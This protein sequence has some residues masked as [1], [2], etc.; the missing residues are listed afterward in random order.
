MQNEEWELSWG[1]SRP[2]HSFYL[3]VRRPGRPVRRPDKLIIEASSLEDVQ[4]LGRAPVQDRANLFVFPQDLKNCIH[5][6]I[7][8]FIADA[9]ALIDCGPGQ[10]VDDLLEGG[11]GEDGPFGGAEGE[12]RPSGRHEG[13]TETSKGVYQPGAIGSAEPVVQPGGVLVDGLAP[14]GPA[15]LDHPA[16]DCGTMWGIGPVTLPQGSAHLRTG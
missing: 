8:I 2:A 1:G 15:V 16:L 6:H 12:F 13:L 10:A 11:E 3:S 14:G 4:D 9:A 5:H 7:E